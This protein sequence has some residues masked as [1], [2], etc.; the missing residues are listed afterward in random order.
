[1]PYVIGGQDTER[2]QVQPANSPGTE[3]PAQR[4]ELARRP[5][6]D[7]RPCGGFM[8]GGTGGR[9]MGSRN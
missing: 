8:L 2:V 3:S 9:M 6:A 4:A 1:M 5:V 7:S